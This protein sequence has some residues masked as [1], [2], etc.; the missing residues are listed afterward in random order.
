LYRNRGDLYRGEWE[1][2]GSQRQVMSVT[3]RMFIWTIQETKPGGGM[4]TG[5]LVVSIALREQFLA[6]GTPVLKRKGT[7]L[8][9]RG[10]PVT[11][12]F[13]IRSGRVSLVLDG[14][15]PAFPP[16][17]LGAGAVVGLP[18]AV[19]GSPYSLTAKVVEDAELAFVPCQAVAECLKQNPAL[20]FEV[21]DIL[22][23]EISG[24]RSALKRGSAR[25]AR[26]N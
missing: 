2:K 18:A 9:S 1:E 13:L 12:L 10:D 4:P 26:E 7:I 20:C 8:F 11:G 23:R 21:M 3:E 6:A 25:L 22:S 5:D 24:T 16:R 17:T 19:G 14:A 15:N